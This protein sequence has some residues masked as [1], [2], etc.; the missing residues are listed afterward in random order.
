MKLIQNY[1]AHYLGKQTITALDDKLIIQYRN[2]LSE[3]TI[4]HKYSEISKRTVTGRSGDHQWT[5]LGWYLL[6]MIAII[7]ILTIYLFPGVNEVAVR[8]SLVLLV[9]GLIAHLMRFVKTE[10]VYFYSKGNE[11]IFEIKITNRNNEI[12]RKIVEYIK[13]HIAEQINKSETRND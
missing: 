3:Y 9:F 11:S 1:P 4:V 13:E 10:R 12:S 5:E 7:R 2:L 8:V 6:L